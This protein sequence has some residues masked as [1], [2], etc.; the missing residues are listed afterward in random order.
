MKKMITFLLALLLTVSASGASVA[1]SYDSS[2]RLTKVD[3]G[4][5]KG[6]VYTWDAMGNLVGK[7]PLP[8]HAGRRRAV[9]AAAKGPAKGGAATVAVR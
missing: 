3:Y 7:G 9:R 8:P 2:G 6:V 5:G 1:Y 4:K